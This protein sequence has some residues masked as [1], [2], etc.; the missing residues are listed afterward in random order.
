MEKLSIKDNIL[1]MNSFSLDE[2]Y[3]ALNRIRN[4]LGYCPFLHIKEARENTKNGVLLSQNKGWKQY[5]CNLKGS[6][7]EYE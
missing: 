2:I 3:E 4:D 6:C 7:K 1:E 5:I